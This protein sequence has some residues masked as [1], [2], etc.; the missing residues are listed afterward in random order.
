MARK[1][2]NKRLI[3]P[4][5]W[6]AEL[7]APGSVHLGR[8]TNLTPSPHAIDFSWITFPAGARGPNNGT[9]PAVA[10][11]LAPLNLSSKTIQVR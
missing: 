8:G 3:V 10:L 6:Q 9:L 4:G 11:F 2:I 5:A 7:L 1:D